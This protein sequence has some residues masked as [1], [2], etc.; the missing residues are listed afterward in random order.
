M[1]N[2][3]TIDIYGEQYPIKGDV[4]IEY[5]KEL[6]DVVDT[7]MRELVK[8]NQ[9][10]PIQRIGVLTALHL[11]DDYFRLKKDYDDLIKLLDK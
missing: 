10:L 2:K 11:A 9:Y 1:E 5:M 8:K 4:D 7:K 6:A 3:L